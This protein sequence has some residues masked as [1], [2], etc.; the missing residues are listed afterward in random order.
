MSRTGKT[1]VAER[2]LLTVPHRPAPPDTRIPGLARAALWVAI[3]LGAVA[4]LRLLPAGAL[5]AL[6]L[7]LVALLALVTWNPAVTVAVVSA[8][9]AAAVI[10]RRRT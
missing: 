4:V 5:V 2:R 8:F 6:G 10:R 9:A 1:G 7:L 3:V